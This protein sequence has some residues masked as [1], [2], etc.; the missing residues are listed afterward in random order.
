MRA[1]LLSCCIVFFELLIFDMV[2][3]CPFSV[4]PP[5]EFVTYVFV[6]WCDRL[7]LISAS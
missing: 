6:G 5:F 4:V 7:I 1:L 3:F 2:F